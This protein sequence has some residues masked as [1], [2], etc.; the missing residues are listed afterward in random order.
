MSGA[1]SGEQILTLAK[2][3]DLPI[4]NK[5][6]TDLPMHHIIS[7][8]SLKGAD[9]LGPGCSRERMLSGADAKLIDR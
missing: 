2:L 3:T 6:M 1:G 9:V 8:S 5:S 4:D 7:H